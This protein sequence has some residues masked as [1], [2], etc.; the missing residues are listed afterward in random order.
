LNLKESFNDFFFFLDERNEGQQNE[1]EDEMVELK[2][3]SIQGFFDHQG[4]I[5]SGEF[6]F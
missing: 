3:D 5:S 6:F 2:D 4:N 1:I